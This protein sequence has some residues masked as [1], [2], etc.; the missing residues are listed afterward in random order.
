MSVRLAI[1][2]LAAGEARRY[3]SNKL[4]SEHPSGDSLLHYVISQYQPL[5]ALPI[6]IVTGRFDN[7]LRQALSTGH[8][9]RI[10]KNEDWQS[11]MG[12]SISTGIRAAMTLADST[13][14][15]LYPTHFM[16]GLADTPLV[17]TEGLREL[18]DKACIFPNAR[19]ASEAE[20]VRMSPAIFPL[21]DEDALAGLTGQKGAAKLLNA[22]APH[23]IAVPFKEAAMD[24]VKPAD[25]Q[26][27]GR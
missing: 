13:P 11:G 6:T 17:T 4:L 5:S 19:I 18:V 8:A 20:G 7:E 25:W 14:A 23:C 16:V 24:I 12:G 1:I 21:S 26:A 2:I 10:A 22:A 3:G 27:L 15:S 9:I